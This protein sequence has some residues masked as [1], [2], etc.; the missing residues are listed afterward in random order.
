MIQELKVW[1]IWNECQQ[2]PN[3]DFIMGP[4]VQLKLF[5]LFFSSC[6]INS[7]DNLEHNTT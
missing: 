6:A 2:Y 1:A 3:L 7:D 4:F 5:N